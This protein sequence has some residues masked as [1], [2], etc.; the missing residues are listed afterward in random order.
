LGKLD[1]FAKKTFPDFAK[2]CE[3]S[4]IKPGLIL[5]GSIILVTLI[6]FIT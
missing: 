2:I 4:K 3:K 5:G 1:E 6:A